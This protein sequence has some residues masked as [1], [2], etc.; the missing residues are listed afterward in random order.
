MLL[1]ILAFLGAASLCYGCYII[2]EPSAFIIAGVMMLAFV[3]FAAR[4]S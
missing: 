4:E 3:I 2:Y 1:D